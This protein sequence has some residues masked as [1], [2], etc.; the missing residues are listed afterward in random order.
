MKEIKSNQDFFL[1]DL[2]K[3]IFF[4]GKEKVKQIFLIHNVVNKKTLSPKTK[5]TLSKISHTF[6]PKF[7]ITGNDLI[8]QGV[9][10]G[11][12]V[13]QLLKKI[14]KKWIENNFKIKDEEIKILVKKNT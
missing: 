1:K 13:G 14:E 3:N 11:R 8:K 6:I 10:R 4:Y 7:P 12:K 5:E 2:K 9:E